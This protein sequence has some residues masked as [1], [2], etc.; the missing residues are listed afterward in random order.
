MTEPYCLLE[1]G[2]APQAGS[3]HCEAA[4]SESTEVMLMDYR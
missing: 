2:E 1:R 4:Y 3:I